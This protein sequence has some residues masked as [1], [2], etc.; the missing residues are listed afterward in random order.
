MHFAVVQNKI[1]RFHQLDIRV[2]IIHR[3]VVMQYPFVGMEHVMGMKHVVRVQ[4]I[5][6]CVQH[7]RV[8]VHRPIRLRKQVQAQ[9]QGQVP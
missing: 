5:V 4:P 9:P 3:V 1:M 8:Q 6:G 2:F 7:P